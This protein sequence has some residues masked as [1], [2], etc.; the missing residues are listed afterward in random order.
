MPLFNPAFGEPPTGLQGL[1]GYHLAEWSEGQAV[2][3]L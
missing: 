1:M 2:V 3:E